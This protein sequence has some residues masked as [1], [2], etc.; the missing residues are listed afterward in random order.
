MTGLRER[1]YSWAEIGRGSASPARLPSNAGAAMTHTAATAALTPEPDGSG[2]GA[3]A[4]D[5]TE[6]IS[7][8]DFRAW[9]RQLATTGTC[10]HPIRLHGRIEAI[11]RATGELAPVYDTSC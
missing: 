9:E 1:G 5:T 8:G 6:T 11:D 4:D 3:I 2:V 7:W 10:S